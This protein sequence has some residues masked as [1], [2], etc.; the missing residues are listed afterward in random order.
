LGELLAVEGVGDEV[1]PAFGDALG[2]VEVLGG[3]AGE[4]LHKGVVG[5][6]IHRATLLRALHAAANGKGNK[7]LSA[8]HENFFLSGCGG[9][10]KFTCSPLFSGSP[11]YLSRK[12]SVVLE[13]EAI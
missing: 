7:Q 12:G 13:R 6:A 10:A 3:D 1:A 9:R 2:S 4:D 5:E 8:D 11:F